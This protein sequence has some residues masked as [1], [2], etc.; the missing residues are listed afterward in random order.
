MI[1]LQNLRFNESKYIDEKIENEIK[2]VF[3][4]DKSNVLKSLT[5]NQS[6]NNTTT[7]VAEEGLVQEKKMILSRSK[8]NTKYLL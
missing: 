4:Y 8:V 3:M 7:I 5:T 1:K 2:N 6:D